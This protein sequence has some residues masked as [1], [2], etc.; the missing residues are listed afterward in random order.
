MMAIVALVV[1]M[2]LVLPASVAAAGNGNGNGTGNAS[3][4]YMGGNGSQQ[5]REEMRERWEEKLQERAER[6]EQMMEQLRERIQERLNEHRHVGDYTYENGTA[7]GVFVEFDL[8][9]GTILDYEL[10]YGPEENGTVIFETISVEGVNASSDPGIH[11][12]VAR[13]EIG[14]IEASSHD[15]PTGLLMLKSEGNS[16]IVLQVA[17]GFEI[18]ATSNRTIKLNDGENGT[19]IISRGSYALD[20]KTITISL[21]DEGKAIFLAWPE[22]GEA[23]EYVE[24]GI[25]NGTIGAEVRV[26]K[27]RP[28]EREHFTNIETDVVY[29]NGTITMNVGSEEEAGKILVITVD[30]ETVSQGALKVTYDGEE[31]QPVEKWKDLASAL[32]QSDAENGT[33]VYFIRPCEGGYQIF[34]AV[35][36]FSDH[37]ITIQGM[38][39]VIKPLAAYVVVGAVAVI[40]AAAAVLFRKRKEE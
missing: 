5:W 7:I 35:P 26:A 23:R 12:S 39:E 11:G 38:A 29:E 40:A 28:I 31:I 17:E 16:T 21:L 36:H 9:N 27:G 30:N 19:I 22:G 1:G 4:G 10:R 25:A 18:N 20:N 34:I 3:G 24:E 37:T 6:R 13:F 2:A 32:K 15:N 14:N 8:E 33:A